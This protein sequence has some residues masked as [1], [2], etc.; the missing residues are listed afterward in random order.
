MTMNA[1]PEIVL[2]GTF[3]TLEPLKREHVEAL[4]LATMDGELW[5]LWYATVPSP[6]EMEAY[7][8][9]ALS[10]ISRGSLPFTVVDNSTGKIVGTT[11]FYSMERAHKRAMLGYTWYARTAQGTAIN[12]DCKFLLLRYFFEQERGNAIEFRTHFFNE[13]SRRAIERLGAKQDGILRSHQIMKDGSIRDTVV[14][15]IITS[16]WPAVRNNLLSRLNASAG[17]NG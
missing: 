11:R 15:S 13:K 1:Y 7:V 5:K 17:K 9:S 8:N 14:Y 3:A 4:K 6:E 2:K 10:D 12:A 16:E